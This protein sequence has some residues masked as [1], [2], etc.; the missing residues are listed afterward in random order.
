MKRL[1]LLWALLMFAVP[2]FAPLAQATVSTTAPRNDYTGTGSVATYSYTFRIFASSDLRLTVRDTAGVETP[3]ALTTDYTVTGV[4]KSTGGTITLVAGNLTSGY[5]L[6]IR[7]DRTPQQA[8]DLRNQGSYFAETHETKFDEL[9]R[10]AQQNRDVLNRTLHLPETEVGTTAATRLLPALL[11]KSS[12]LGFDADGHLTYYTSLISGGASVSGFAATLLDDADAATARTTLGVPA[13]TSGAATSLICTTCTAAA[14]PVVALGLATKQYVDN[15]PAGNV[16]NYT[17]TAN[18]DAGVRAASLSGASFVLTLPAAASNNG[19]IVTILHGGTS[20]TD[21]YT[22]KG[23]GAELVDGANTYLLYTTRERVTFICNGTVWV[24]LDHYAKTEWFN[25]GVMTITGTGSNPTKPT[26]PDLDTV[27]WRREGNQVF[28][29]YV[30]QVSSAAGSAAGGGN[31][32]FAL[33]AGI[34]LDTTVIS[35]VATAISGAVRSEAVRSM[36]SGTGFVN[37]DSTSVTNVSLFAYDTSHFQV[38]R[39]NTLNDAV[40]ATGATL[41]NAELSYYFEFSARAADWRL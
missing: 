11:R 1:W 13:A 12:Y 33:P 5:A 19:R 38:W 16:T 2:T 8:T 31:Y 6:T 24:M 25:A 7:F 40:G 28:L 35:P 10:Y 4:N 37:V 15:I 23:N 22:I 26:T 41:T 17:G 9:T 21:V 39:L 32:L 30:L 3:L 18:L 34:T 27:Y 29:R 14:D 20:L 36:L